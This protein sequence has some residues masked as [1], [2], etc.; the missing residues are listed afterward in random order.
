MP[1]D[2]FGIAAGMDGTT[3]NIT[4]QASNAVSLERAINA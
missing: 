3:T 2:L 4:K 1:W